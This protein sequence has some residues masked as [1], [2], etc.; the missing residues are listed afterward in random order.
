MNT[1]ILEDTDSANPDSQETSANPTTISAEQF[2]ALME[3]N[4]LL[5]DEIKNL[6]DANKIRTDSAAA[7]EAESLIEQ[8]K[9]QQ[10]YETEQ[11]NTVAAKAA[12]DAF[13]ASIATQLIQ[14]KI[15]ASLGAK[16]ITDTDKQDDLIPA[17]TRKI[18]ATMD[19]TTGD[20][21]GDFETEVAKAVE[22]WG[23]TTADATQNKSGQAGAFTVARLAG[24]VRPGQANNRQ[25]MSAEEY[26][27]SNLA[28]ALNQTH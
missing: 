9:F 17:L 18:G 11:S 13:R 6:K 10:L 27:R 15:R 28:S 21:T 7:A 19:D 26:T 20:I 2:S 3:S 24:S 14:S 5:T 22:R 8:S 25:P 16:G 12:S 23:T 4:K 1:N